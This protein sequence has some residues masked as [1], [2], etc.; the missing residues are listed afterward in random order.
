[1]KI[2]KK[3]LINHVVYKIFKRLYVSGYWKVPWLMPPIR[4]PGIIELELSNECNFSCIHCHRRRMFRK[5]GL[6]EFSVYKKIIDEL[7]AYPFISLFFVGQGESTLNPKFPEMMRYAAGKSLKID[8]TTNG[9]LFDLYSFEE[10]LQWDIDVIGISVDGT[11][12]TSYEQIRRG[13][14]YDK[15]KSNISRFYAY[16]NENNRT[17]P[18]ISLRNVIFPDNTPQQIENFKETWKNSVDLITFNTLSTFQEPINYENLHY[19][20]C[21]QIFFDAHIRYDGSVILCQHQ[22]LYDRDEVIGDMKINSIREIWKSGRLKERRMLHYKRD[23]PQ[24][25]KMCF[26][27]K[28]KDAVFTNARKYNMSNN[29]IINWANKFL[30]VT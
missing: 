8:L 26:S 30:N 14:N 7:S 15:L 29:F 13:G 25:C 18:L 17:Y 10:I 28:K 20:R 21:N 16:R 6:M 2:V 9:T 11:D 5:P 4:N 1:M 27:D 23:F 22:C 12:K 3:K 24:V 19:H